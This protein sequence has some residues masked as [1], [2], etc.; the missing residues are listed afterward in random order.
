MNLPPP[1]THPFTDLPSA[2]AVGTDPEDGWTQ[3]VYDQHQIAAHE[4]ETG[5]TYLWLHLLEDRHGRP[6]HG[7]TELIDGLKSLQ[8]NGYRIVDRR[9]VPIKGGQTIRIVTM[10]GL[11]LDDES[12]EK[13]VSW[14]YR[15]SRRAIL[16]RDLRTNKLNICA[17]TAVVSRGDL[18]TL[19]NSLKYQDWDVHSQ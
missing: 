3:I 18:A 12:I 9:P 10:E 7:L 11:E 4:P 15:L 14:T 5:E 2:L 13:G 1:T 17:A 6:L 19:S 16:E 8:E